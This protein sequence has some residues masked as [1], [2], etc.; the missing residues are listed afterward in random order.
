MSLDIVCFVSLD[1]MLLTF[2]LLVGFELQGDEFT[3]VPDM[4]PAEI[5]SRAYVQFNDISAK[6]TTTARAS[7]DMDIADVGNIGIKN[8][9][10]AFSFGLGMIE[11]ADKIYFNE[12][13]SV[14]LALKNLEW[15]TAAVMDVSIPLV[16]TIQF[17][18]DLDLTLSP[19]I[20]ITSSDFFTPGFPVISLD[21][22]LP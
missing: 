12:I 4:S 16:A 18:E 22:N 5:A 8:G 6:F 10:I 7:G 11:V 9:T 15:Q 3:Q 17:A 19:I 2:Q 20:S 14:V 13:S 1:V 21:L